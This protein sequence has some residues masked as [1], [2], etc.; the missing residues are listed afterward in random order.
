MRRDS[1]MAEIESKLN[2]MEK[3]LTERLEAIAKEVYS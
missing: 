2:N 3:R 1:F